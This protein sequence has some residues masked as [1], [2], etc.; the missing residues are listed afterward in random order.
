MWPVEASGHAKSHHFSH[1]AGFVFLA[2]TT[3]ARSI[4]SGAWLFF[5]NGF[6]FRF[7]AVTTAFAA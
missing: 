4:S 1:A 6:W 5:A 7:L 2:A 3:G